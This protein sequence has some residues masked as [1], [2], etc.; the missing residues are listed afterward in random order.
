MD[1][2]M[3]VARLRKEI[4]TLKAELAILKGDHQG[5]ETLADFEKERLKKAYNSVKTAVEIFVADKSHD[6]ALILNQF[7]QIQYA[8]QLLKGYTTSTVATEENHSTHGD[9]EFDARGLNSDQIKKFGK[10]QHLVTHRDN[11]ISSY[12]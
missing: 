11:E 12:C 7:R 10:L 6:A 8:F 4:E 2:G 3:L 9:L 5:D 1:P